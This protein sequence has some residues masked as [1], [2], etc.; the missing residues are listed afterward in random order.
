LAAR[1]QALDRLDPEAP[2]Q[3]QRA[4]ELVAS[5]RDGRYLLRGPGGRLALTQAAVT[6]AA[7]MDGTYVLRT[8]DDPLPPEDV[9]LGSTARRR[10]EAG[11][12]RM[13][14]TGRRLRPVS[15]G[16]GHR[17][18]SHVKRCVLALLLQRAA[19][20]RPGATWRPIR[21]LLDE[22]K[23]VRDR[24]RGTTIVPRT[25]LTPQAAPGLKERRVA[26][27]ERRLAVAREASC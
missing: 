4:G 6:R 20:M 22:V 21:R 24:V 25:R 19:E 26:P 10:L 11:C 12:R 15:H 14:T 23:A 17:I 8:H 13:K 5:P 1:R 27:P 18:A 2:A 16:T 7:R 9:G 3:T